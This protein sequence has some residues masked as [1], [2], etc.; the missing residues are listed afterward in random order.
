L[1]HLPSSGAVAGLVPTHFTKANSASGTIINEGYSEEWLK[2]YSHNHYFSCDPTKN[3]RFSGA[4]FLRWSDTFKRA[5]KDSEKRYIRHAKEYGIH[6]GVT[7]G[8]QRATCGPISFFAFL[9]DNLGQNHRDEILLRY[10]TPYLHE[11]MCRAAPASFLAVEPTNHMLLSTRETEVLSWAMAG[12]TNWEISVI[13]HISE[14]TVKFHIQNV[15]S[16]LQA[17]SRAH[18]VAI[19]LGQGLICA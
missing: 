19:A 17:S 14:R 6:D 12:K 4:D 10:L 9:G 8:T 3:A 2:E 16:K 18:A 15:M 5:E 11:A 13:L 1:C 7:V